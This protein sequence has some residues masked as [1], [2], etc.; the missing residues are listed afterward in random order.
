MGITTA[1]KSVVKPKK[2]FKVIKTTT[3][4]TKNIDKYLS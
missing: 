2:L 1:I 3:K 4:H